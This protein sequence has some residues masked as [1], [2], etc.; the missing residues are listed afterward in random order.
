MT[1]LVLGIMCGA[2]LYSLALVRWP[3]LA[4]SFMGAI[5]GFLAASAVGA[6]IAWLIGAL[7]GSLT[8]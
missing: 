4:R 5:C 6:A 1:A 8:A 2:S 7:I 3:S